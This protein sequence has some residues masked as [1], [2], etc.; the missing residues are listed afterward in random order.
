M[1]Q[2]QRSTYFRNLVTIND[3]RHSCHAIAYLGY[4]V[5]EHVLARS[6]YVAIPFFCAFTLCKS[7]LQH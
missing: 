5:V 3:V 4:G 7:G 2:A 6:S 1:M